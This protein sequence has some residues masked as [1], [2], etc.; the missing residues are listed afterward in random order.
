MNSEK[1]DLEAR[2]L[3]EEEAD[4]AWLKDI[5]NSFAGRTMG[6]VD[7]LVEE[8]TKDVIR[9]RAEERAEELLLSETITNSYKYE[10]PISP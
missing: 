3:K 5:R 10:R 8:E 6:F 7:H 4:K 1:K 9:Q 2:L